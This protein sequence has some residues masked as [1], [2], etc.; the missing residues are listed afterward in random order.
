VSGADGMSGSN[1]AAISGSSNT[2][3]ASSLAAIA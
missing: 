2:V 1:M 3:S